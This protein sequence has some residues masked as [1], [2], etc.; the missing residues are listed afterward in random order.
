MNQRLASGDPGAWDDAVAAVDPAS[1]LV[2]IS[3][4]LGPELR[5]RLEPED[6][7]QETLLKAWAARA[8]FEWRGPSAFRGWLL[9]IAE[10]CIDD[11]S[12]R[13]RTQ[14]RGAELTVPLR[15]PGDGS[16]S[17]AGAPEPF[18]S[19]TPSRI[20]AERERARAME[21]ALAGLPDEY[22]EVVRL[23][24]VEDVTA[25]EVGSRL[26]IGESAVRHRFRKGAELYRAKLRELLPESAMD[27]NGAGKR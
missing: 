8:D 27:G 24:L 15:A 10:R 4:R 19:T 14:K 1:V 12:D 7:W 20:A 13:L 2:A 21:A 6:I 17:G 26:G 18:G 3:S 9:R 11:Q 16:A 23:R 22:R 25:G 5:K